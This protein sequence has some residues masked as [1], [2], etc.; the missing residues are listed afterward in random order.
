MEAMEAMLS[1]RSIR[2]Y[3]QQ[4]VSS[5]LVN[6]LL[7]AAMSAP[8]A[9][10]KQPWH[11]IIINNRELLDSIP[12]FHPFA[13]MLYLA[14]L[15]I[16]V[17][18]DLKV[19]SVFWVQDCSAASENILL[20]A[21]ASGLGAV[22]VSVYPREERVQGLRNLLGLPEHIIP[23]SLISLG[24]PVEKKSPSKRYNP[25]KVHHNGW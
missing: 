23:L 10:N 2:K 11:F 18:G 13:D 24:Y 16:A 15:A 12:Q 4:P 3:T 5:E 20:A 9:T 14:P 6:E 21:H 1:R 17:C 19:Q 7:K 8:S 22:W 25:E